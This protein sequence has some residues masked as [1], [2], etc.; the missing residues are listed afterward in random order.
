LR[1]YRDYSDESASETKY[2][3]NVLGF[4]C[5]N[6]ATDKLLPLA[7]TLLDAG[8]TYTKEDS[9][10]EWQLAKMA[11]DATELN[12]QQMRHLVETHLVSVPIQVE[13]IRSMAEN[14]PIYALLD[15][16]L[17]A[18]MALEN[19]GGAILFARGSPYDQSMAS[20]AGGSMRFIVAEFERHTLSDDLPTI[21]RDRGLEHLP[22]HRYV[23]YGTAYYSAVKAFVRAYVEVYYPAEG[24]IAMDAEL[25]TWAARASAVPE[26]HGFPASFQSYDDLVA[27]V[28]HLVFQNAVKHHFMNGR[29]SWHSQAAPFSTPALFGATPLPSSKGVDVDPMDYA[30]P[31]DVFPVLSYMAARFHRPI[32]SKFTA[33]RAYEGSPFAD[34]PALAP[35]IEHF[36]QLMRLL[37][38]Y[39]DNMESKEPFPFAFVKPSLLPWFSYI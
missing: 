19:R 38:T 4:F 6:D 3:P 34:E 31:S 9:A 39:V 25:Q 33:L 7:I 11:L 22:N 10:G 20:G 14:H 37:E 36:H 1:G 16:H 24:L 12:Y 28:T 17:F 21:I 26:V 2:A 13:L 35:H 15:Y 30:I 27:L 32:P 8:L 23:R 18:D 5:Q 29:V